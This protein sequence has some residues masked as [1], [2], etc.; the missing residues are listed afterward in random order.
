MEII[1][2]HDNKHNQDR[3]NIQESDEKKTNAIYEGTGNG[4]NEVTYIH[5]HL[6]RL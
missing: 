5:A 3:K 2:E 1:M 6:K 4:Q